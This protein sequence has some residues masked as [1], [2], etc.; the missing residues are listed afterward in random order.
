M[1]FQTT[2]TDS[3]KSSLTNAPD[4]FSNEA[5]NLL[6][7]GENEARRWRHEFLDVEHILQALFTDSSYQST[8]ESLPINI[9]DILDGLENFLAGLPI[10]NTDKLF[11]GEDLEELLD[12]A[13]NFRKRWGSRSIEVSHLLIALGRDKRIGSE[14]FKEVGLPSELLES[15]LRRLPKSISRKSNK[16][17]KN[18]YKKEQK[19]LETFATGFNKNDQKEIIQEIKSKHN[20]EDNQIKLEKEENPLE[21]FGKD[22]T[23]AAQN[24]E[25]DPVIGRDKEIKSTIK[26]L[27]RRGKNNPV[28][29]G[30]PGVGKTAIAELLAQRIICNE[31]PESLKGL[32]LISLDIGALIAGTKFRGQF[33]ERLRSVLKEASNPES[34]VI[35]FIDELHTLLSTD[36]SSADAGSLLKPILASGDLRCIGTTTPEHYR[37]TIEKDQ[38]LNRRFQQVFIKEPSIELSVEILRGIKE[39]YELHH[40]V[41]IS[42]QALITANKLADRYINDRCLPDKA[43]DL[44]DEAAAQIKIEATS[45]PILIEE[46]EY[47]LI[48]LSKE[49]IDAQKNNKEEEYERINNQIKIKEGE[50][51]KLTS[52]WEAYKSNSKEL[53]SLYNEDNNIRDLINSAEQAGNLEEAAKLQYDTLYNL[54]DEILTTEKEI[55]NYLKSSILSPRKSQVEPEDIADVVANWTG[56]PVNKVMAGEKQKLLNL[57]KDLANKVIGQIEAVKAVAEAIKRAR[58]GMKDSYRPIGSFLFLGPTGVGKTELAKALAASLFDEEEALI[59]LDMS[60]FMERNAVARLLGAPPGYV[61]YEEGG[62]LTEAVRRRPYSVILLDELEKAHPDVFNILLQVL[63]DGRLTDSQGITVDFRHTVI[64]MTSNLAS[65]KILDSTR[66]SDE[67]NNDMKKVSN[68]LKTTIDQLLKKQFRPEFLNRIDEIIHFSPL[69]RQDI[70]EIIKLQLIELTNLLAEQNLELRVDSSTIEN[71]ASEGFEPEYG[72]RPLRRIIRRRIENPLATKLLEDE[73]N[74]FR[75]VRIKTSENESKTLEFQG[76]H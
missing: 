26:V 65:R 51:N 3:M 28:L 69:S 6:L 30:P 72:A 64:V 63:D 67:N 49:L 59:R 53:E 12:C 5:W 39:R 56:I 74:G 10:T 52:E 50:V 32:K 60:E 54:Q 22:L 68:S 57:E 73:F 34:K 66:F 9:E 36:R 17:E 47:A 41:N 76:E 2:N 33:E 40:A 38:A 48:S 71:L 37:K 44:I 27:S 19:S 23:L 15:E 61:G 29:I 25:L 16:I 8:V 75:A 7:A 55:D 13:D 46:K 20:S 31:V 18:S 62:Q 35:L 70:Q 11:V 24:Q 43:I 42:D 45:K 4:S 58:A 14:L 21:I 1:Q